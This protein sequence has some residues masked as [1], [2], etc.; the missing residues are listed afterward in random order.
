[1]LIMW[2]IVFLRLCV[3][4]CVRVLLIFIFL[5]WLY[6]CDLLFKNNTTEV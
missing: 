1:M 3:C 2:G 6:T 5:E 4:V